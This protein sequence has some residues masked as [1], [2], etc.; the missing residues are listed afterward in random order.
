VIRILIADDHAIVRRGL[1]QIVAEQFDQPVIGEAQNASEVLS[2]VQTQEW[3]VAVLDISMP[4]RGGLE[5]LGKLKHERPRLPVLILSIHSE[6]QYARRALK[7]GAAGYLNKESAPEEL[8][9][10]IRTVLAG[11]KY[12][13]ASLAENL[14]TA[15][16]TE[17]DKA[18][19]ELLSDREYQVLS[20]LASGR[21]VGEI[22]A[23]LSLSVKTISTYRT[24]ILEKMH[25]NSN[26]EL[27]HYAIQQKLVP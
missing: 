4:G 15:L 21:T 3:D 11:R 2:L 27:I 18:P 8:V 23:Q 19:H 12:V 1:K 5:I 9:K 24:R 16:G 22:A 20:L 13:S 17:S 25:L 7:A 6:D 14:V 26:A 10:A